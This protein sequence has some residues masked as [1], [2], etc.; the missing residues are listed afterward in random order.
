MNGQ[1]WDIVCSP[2]Y[3]WTNSAFGQRWLFDDGHLY[4]KSK[5]V[6]PKA[7][8]SNFT[9]CLDCNL[10][11]EQQYDGANGQKRHHMLKG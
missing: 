7:E 6:K 8:K 11:G 3:S 5:I 1:R 4:P 2:T 10:V 9:F